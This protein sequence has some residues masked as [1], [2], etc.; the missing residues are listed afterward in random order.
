LPTLTACDSRGAY[1][2]YGTEYCNARATVITISAGWCSACQAEAPDIE[3]T[4]T[5]GYR[6]SAVRVVTLL[7][8]NSDRSPA[9]A[10]FCTRWQSRFGLSSRMVVDPRNTISSRVRVSAYPTVVIVDRRGRLRM[11]ETA[12]RISRIQSVLNTILAE[13]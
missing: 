5:Q 6:A 8:E 4:I 7:T 13:P 11:S 3:R 1:D 10:D 2:F 9:T 12:P